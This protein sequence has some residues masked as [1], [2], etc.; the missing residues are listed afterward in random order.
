MA[1][2]FTEVSRRIDSDQIEIIVDVAFDGTY[3]ADGEAVTKSDFDLPIELIH[4]AD[5]VT[6]DGYI[7]HFVPST[8]KLKVFEAGTASA[9]LDEVDGT[10]LGSTVARLVV[11]G[12]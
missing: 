1:L 9:A 10:E 5:A 11:H 7:V 8:S 6:D 3:P 4:I 12:K 2:G